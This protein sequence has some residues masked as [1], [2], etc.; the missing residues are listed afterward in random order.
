MPF[1]WTCRHTDGTIFLKEKP[2]KSSEAPDSSCVHQHRW[3]QS[4]WVTLWL[5]GL[6][7][8][9]A[10]CLR[11]AEQQVKWEDAENDL[12]TSFYRTFC[13]RFVERKRYMWRLSK[14][15]ISWILSFS[16]PF[17]SPELFGVQ[18]VF[19][20]QF[21]CEKLIWMWGSQWG[22][23][24]LFFPG[25]QHH[26]PVSYHLIAEPSLKSEWCLSGV[27]LA[28]CLQAGDGRFVISAQVTTVLMKAIQP[29]IY[30]LCSE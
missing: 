13:L 20:M 1:I 2:L 10:A 14:Q 28:Q 5:A 21:V 6:I 24:V 15:E 27:L 11:G 26:P 17:Y 4:P 3:S 23:L 25:S 22:L 7:L 29:L 19:V 16:F 30:M 12:H 18:S 9:T 8:S